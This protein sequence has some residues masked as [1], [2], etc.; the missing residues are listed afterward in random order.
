[1]STEKPIPGLTADPAAVELERFHG[2]IRLSIVNRMLTL[3]A[4]VQ[5]APLLLTAGT[6]GEI[7]GLVSNGDARLVKDCIAELQRGVERI[8]ALPADEQRKRLDSIKAQLGSLLKQH[9]QERNILRLAG[10]SCLGKLPH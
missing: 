3:P 5:G 10:K 7:I 1:M 8:A 6:V 2:Q 4:E 9:R